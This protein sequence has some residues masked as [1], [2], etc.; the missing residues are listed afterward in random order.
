MELC[1]L[2]LSQGGR[3]YVVG[4]EI[5]TIRKPAVNALL[6]WSTFPYCDQ[7]PLDRKML[8]VLLLSCVPETEL[9]LGH[10]KPT[11]KIFIEGEIFVVFSSK[12]PILT[13]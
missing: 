7:K 8:E 11:V 2:C 13:N 1:I 9:M 4:N 12:S 10:V 3:K 6:M 5:L